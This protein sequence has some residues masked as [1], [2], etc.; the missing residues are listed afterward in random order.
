MAGMVF[1]TEQTSRD[2]R[3]HV[4]AG[5]KAD[6][7]NARLLGLL[8]NILVSDVLMAFNGAGKP[9]V[10]RAEIAANKA[11]SLDPNTPL[12]YFALG[13]VHRIH[14]DH[15]A[16]FDEFDKATKI[17][18]NLAK[19]YAQAGN[20]MVFTGNPAGAIPLA[21]K[22]IQLSPFDPALATFT[23]VQGRALFA[24]GDYSK[25]IG[26][27]EQSARTLQSIWF[28]L[29]WL[30]AAYSLTGQNAKAQQAL[31]TLRSN[32]PHFDLN[33]ITQ[34]YQEKQYDNPTLKQA[35]T[36]LLKGLQMAGLK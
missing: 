23:W 11:I 33:R 10:D 6:P 12:A 34:I 4:E 7:D 24:L 8:A 3:Q 18:P 16:A 22:A 36:E 19:A 9:E 25:A 14:G 13:C 2:T 21:E 17:D 15:Q 35:S 31:Q 26:P 27:L 30:T 5:L 29:A 20:E 32:F 28:P 1:T